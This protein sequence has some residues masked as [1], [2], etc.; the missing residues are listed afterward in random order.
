MQGERYHA[1]DSLRAAMMLAGIWMHGVQ[2]YTQLK[3]Y[4]W[5]FKDVAR[6][7]VFDFTINW[8]HIFRMPVFFAMAGFFFALL[9]ER[10]GTSGAMLNRAK[11]ILAP[12]VLAWVVLAPVLLTTIGR[13]RVGSWFGGWM[14]ALDVRNYGK[15]GPLHLWFLEYLLLLYPIMLAA[16]WLVRRLFSGR[17]LTA[18][19]RAFRAV[20][21]SR[22]RAP[23]AAVIAG[24]P[25]YL[26]GGWLSTPHGFAPDGH[27]AGAYLVFFAF[28]WVLYF[29]RDVLARMAS[30][31]WT[32]IAAGTAISVVG[33]AVLL[34]AVHGDVWRLA[35]PL[36]TWLFVFGFI[37]VAMRRIDRPIVWVR[38]LSD[39]SYWMYLLH[40]P[41]LIWIQLLIAPLALPALMKGMLALTMAMPLLLAS[42]HFAVRPTWLGAL[43]NGRRYGVRTGQRGIGRLSPVEA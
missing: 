10:R 5:P 36:G 20:V 18:G 41:L 35:G 14:G 2:C 24:G 9:T 28:G 30:G 4:M 15:I 11:R 33:H 8:V 3:V 22:W 13:L 39:A 26:M 40:V 32:E 23:I 21:V 43:L 34:G 27:I 7:Q 25:M 12:F 38:Y 42:Y 6:S 31:G 16:D 17:V 29:E 1:F 37:A 19:S